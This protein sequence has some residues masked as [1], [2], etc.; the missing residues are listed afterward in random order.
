MYGLT[1]AGGTSTRGTFY[2]FDVGMKPFVSLVQTSGAVGTSVGILGQ[3]FTGASQVSFTGAN[4]VFTVI[5]DTY[6]TARV[7]SGA[8]TGIVSVKTPAGRLKSNKIFRVT[9]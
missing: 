5:S 1:D 2:S 3:G 6:L 4:A 8:T 7:P 9:Q